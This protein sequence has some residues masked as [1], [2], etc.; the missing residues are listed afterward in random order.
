[1]TSILKKKSKVKYSIRSNYKN[2]IKMP[3]NKP[4]QRMKGLDN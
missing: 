1:M 3:G 2:K 4:N